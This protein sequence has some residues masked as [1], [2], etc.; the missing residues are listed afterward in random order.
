MTRGARVAVIGGSRAAEMH[1]VSLGFGRRRGRL[2]PATYDAVLLTIGRD[3]TWHDR[4]MRPIGSAAPLQVL[5]RLRRR[6]PAR[7]RSARRDG[8]LAALCDWAACR[9]SGPGVGRA[10]SRWTSGSPSWSPARS[11]SPPPRPPGDPGDRG[12]RALD[13]PGGGGPVAAGSSH[14]VTLAD[15]PDAIARPSTP[16]ARSTAGRWSTS[17]S[18]ARSTWRCYDVSTGHGGLPALEIVVDGV[19]DYD[20]SGGADLRVPAR[21]EEVDA[22]ALEDAALAYD[23][24][25]CSGVARIDFFLTDDGPV[26]SNEVNTVPGPTEHSPGPRMFAAAGLA[27]PTCSTGSSRRTGE[28]GS[29]AAGHPPHRPGALHDVASVGTGRRRRPARPPGGTA[30]GGE[31]PG[32]VRRRPRPAAALVA[33]R[34]ATA[35]ALCRHLPGAALGLVWVL[36]VAR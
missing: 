23:A 18:A 13:P 27:T 24:L 12:D 5:A 16:L 17:S 36:G 33:L 25:G 29:L 28:C 35:V 19:F 10:R 15:G 3:G 8:A 20:L 1:E 2:D 14:G 6:L 7:A 32:V 4:G 30:R 31:P 9:T 26:L 34:V 22:K 11:A 21:L